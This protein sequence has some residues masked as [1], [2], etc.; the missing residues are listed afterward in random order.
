MSKGSFSNIFC[1]NDSKFK[2]IEFLGNTCKKFLRLFRS[3]RIWRVIE[4]YRA[5]EN[6]VMDI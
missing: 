1:I 2:S 4:H 3:R 5:A 6:N